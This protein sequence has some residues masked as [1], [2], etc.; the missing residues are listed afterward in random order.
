MA[1]ADGLSRRQGPI[2][3]GKTVGQWVREQIKR[4]LATS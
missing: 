3:A 2:L 4:F 1:R